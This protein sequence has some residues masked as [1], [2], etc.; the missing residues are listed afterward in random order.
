MKSLFYLPFI[1]FSI[2]IVAPSTFAEQISSDLRT[3]SADLLGGD[4]KGSLDVSVNNNTISLT[5]VMDV[6]SEDKQVYEGWFQDKDD[7]SGYFLSLGKFNEENNTLTINQTMV[8]PYTYT[9][10]FVTSEP[11]DDPDPNPSDI[12]AIAKL[13]NPFG[14]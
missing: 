13:D 14:K 1:L 9:I 8:N 6:P 3:P 10:F 11:I 5:A 7:G 12:I 4:K 2:G